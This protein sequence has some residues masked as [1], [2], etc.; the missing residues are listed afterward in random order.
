MYE[1]SRDISKIENA[2]F[3]K[4]YNNIR[5]MNTRLS[6]LWNLFSHNFLKPVLSVTLPVRDPKYGILY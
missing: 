6:I 2:F 3:K 1:K 4:L 5:S